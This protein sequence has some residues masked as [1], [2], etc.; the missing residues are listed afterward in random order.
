MPTVVHVYPDPP[1]DADDRTLIVGG[2]TNR[3]IGARS[4]YAWPPACQRSRFWRVEL[5]VRRWNWQAGRPGR[6]EVKLG[7]CG[8]C[9][10]D[11]PTDRLWII[12]QLPTEHTSL[13]ESTGRNN[14]CATITETC[15]NFRKQKGKPC[16]R[17]RLGRMA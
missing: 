9:C 8:V 13:V 1:D 17:Y 16:A 2:A 4:R 10:D 11:V 12:R 15:A 5:G 14:R 7:E 6:C 3:M